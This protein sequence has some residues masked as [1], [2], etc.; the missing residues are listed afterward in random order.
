[1]HCSGADQ[2]ALTHHLITDSTNKCY[3]F[4]GILHPRMQWLTNGLDYFNK[5]ESPVKTTLS[6]P[7]TFPL[8]P[9]CGNIIQTSISHL[10]FFWIH[11]LFYTHI[12]IDTVYTHM[13]YVQLCQKC[14][15]QK[16]RF[17]SYSS[18]SNNKSPKYS[19]RSRN[20]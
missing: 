16:W 12:I 15:T 20:K 2:F 9:I 10:I 7:P 8:S 5:E 19:N 14:V 1:M 11:F 13:F 4:L 17:C 18:L 3:R 6:N